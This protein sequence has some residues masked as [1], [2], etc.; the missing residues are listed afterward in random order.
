V[1]PVGILSS[2]ATWYTVAE[3]IKSRLWRAS[4]NYCFMVLFKYSHKSSRWLSY[5][6]VLSCGLPSNGLVR[7]ECWLLWDIL[8][9]PNSTS[10]IL[11]QQTEWPKM[12]SKVAW[13][14][15][16]S[17]FLLNMK[18]CHVKE[19]FLFLFFVKSFLYWRH[20]RLMN[21]CRCSIVLLLSPHFVC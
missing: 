12:G 7:S 21:V 5:E 6:N 3:T 2:N 20:I 16:I 11:F 4:N 1:S 14:D 10:A 15:K 19:K 9:Y 8:I 17:L 13:T 18:S